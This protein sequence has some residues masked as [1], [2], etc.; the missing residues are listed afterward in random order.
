MMRVPKMT[1]ATVELI[2]AATSWVSLQ[3]LGQWSR[4]QEV[5]TMMSQAEMLIPRAGPRA[6]DGGL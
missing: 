1:R 6:V 2:E 4:S 3:R 5:S